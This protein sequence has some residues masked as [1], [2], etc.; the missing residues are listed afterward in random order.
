MERT[1]V[2]SKCEL[3]RELD[4]EQLR[5]VEGICTPVTFQPGEALGKQDKKNEFLYVIEEGLVGIVVEKGPLTQ[6]QVQAAT[7]Y[8]VVGWSSMI[9]PDV[10]LATGKALEETKVLAFNGQEL[11]NL[12]TSD[13]GIGCKIC[14]GVAR[15]VAGRLHHAYDQLLGC[16]SQD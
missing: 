1:E 14:K 7:N 13:P 12:C 5:F 15:V 11:C 10:Y 3:F 6:R 2:L 8:D 16:T 9:L 4:S